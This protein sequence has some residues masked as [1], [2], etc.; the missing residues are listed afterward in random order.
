MTHA[1]DKH[2]GA[3]EPVSVGARIKT[4]RKARGWLQHGLAQRAGLSVSTISKVES[5]HLAASPIVT[6][7]CARAL[8]VPVTELTGQPYLDALKAEELEILVQPLRQAIANPMLPGEDIEPRPLAAIRA[9]VARLDATRLLGEYM[10]IGTEVPGLIDELLVVVDR[11]PEGREREAAYRVLADAYRLARSFAGK[12]G[13][14]DL[15]LLALDRMQ[16]TIPHAGD[17]YLSAAVVYYRSEYFLHHGFAEIALREISRVERFLEE[18]VRRGSSRAVS[19]RGALYLKSA[20]LHSRTGAPGAAG[21]VAARIGEARGLAARLAGCPDPYG[22][23]FDSTNVELHAASTQLDLGEVGRMVEMGEGI[24]MPAGWAK[25]RESHHHMDMGRAYELMGRREDALAALERARHAA[26][27]Q[28][29]Y[30]PTTRETV[31][32]LLRARGTPSAKLRGYARWVG[33]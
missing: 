32:A 10:P 21:E 6:A 20:V 15:S 25:N 14:T 26:P 11:V 4:V 33:V 13:F 1:T 3:P 5:G 16:Q 31:H 24:R 23:I 29:R 17:P 7:A 18:P 22:L 19:V 8:R 2:T 28:T 9:D 27:A 30:H 12:L